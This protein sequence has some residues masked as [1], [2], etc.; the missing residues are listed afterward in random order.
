[1][2]ECIGKVFA[3]EE[4][5]VNEWIIDGE[6]YMRCVMEAPATV[7]M[8]CAC[9]VNRLPDIIAAEPGYVT[10]EKMADLKLHRT[11]E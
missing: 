8:T 11:L 1:M 2:T 9:A 6:P 4:K 7:E 10:S 3:P 5:D